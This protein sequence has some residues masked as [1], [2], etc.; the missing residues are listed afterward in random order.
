MKNKKTFF[1]VVLIILM[2]APVFGQRKATAQ[3]LVGTWAMSTVSGSELRLHADG[4]C[5]FY[6]PALGSRQYGLW[7]VFPAMG[8]SVLKVGY[9]NGAVDMMAITYINKNKILAENLR[10][11]GSWYLLRK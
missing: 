7:V 2:L 4:N 5:T 10:G 11:S 9:T 8:T 1:A 3:D 6:A